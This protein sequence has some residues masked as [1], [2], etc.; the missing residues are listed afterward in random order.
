[1]L[2]T[3]H[4]KLSGPKPVIGR[5]GSGATP[6]GRPALACAAM[7]LLVMAEAAA[8]SPRAPAHYEPSW[9]S[10]ARHETP[11]W[12]EDAKFGIFIHWGVYSVPAFGNEWYPRTCTSRARRSS[13]TT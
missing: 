3:R 8:Q 12:Y 10:L 9:V 13:S 4:A 1:M 7:I 6:V 11:K 2:H 5:S